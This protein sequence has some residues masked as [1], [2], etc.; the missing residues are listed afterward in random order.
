MGLESGPGL[1]GRV[2]ASSGFGADPSEYPP[3]V[4]SVPFL[5]LRVDL[6]PRESPPR[7]DFGC[8]CSAALDA[9]LM[10]VGCMRRGG[11]EDS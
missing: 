10:V 2:G 9:L 4:R 11:V 5:Q 6:S 3:D 1:A 7:F 8:G